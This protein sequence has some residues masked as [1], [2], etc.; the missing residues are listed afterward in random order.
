MA[1]YP[2]LPLWTDAYLADTRHLT[3]RQH[4]A[5]LLLLM[6]AWR[7]P[8]CSLPDD[9]GLLARLSGL[10]A[11]EWAEDGGEVL[12]F[13]NRDGR[14]KTWTQDRLTRERR[15]VASKSLSQRDKSLKRWKAAKKDDAVGMP[16]GMPERCR[17]D[18]PTPTPTPTIKDEP[19][20]SSKKH[21][22][23]R[24]PEDAVISERQIEIAVEQGHDSDEAHA[25][26][27]LFKDSA[28]QHGRLYVDWDRAWRNWFRSPYFRQ[29]NGL[30]LGNGGRNGK[31]ASSNEIGLAAERIAGL[32]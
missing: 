28:I 21:T 5:Y 4:G 3:T 13:F 31:R 22:K 20:V 30:P 32:R 23:S 29:V 15:Y 6:E 17:S 16:E 14:K 19:K 7:R 11:A 24:I 1:D 27:D 9:D 26:F 25:Q 12:A 18:A 8:T 2:A 10:S